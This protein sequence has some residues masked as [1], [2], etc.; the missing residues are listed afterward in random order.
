MLK[1]IKQGL[2]AG[3]GAVLLTKDKV[4]EAVQKLVKESKIN[5]AEA[6]KLTRELV[7]SGEK[8]WEDLEAS[9]GKSVR[10][11]VQSLDIASKKELQA[12]KRKVKKLEGRMTLIEEMLQDKKES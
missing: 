4:D 1:E 3:L 12:L 10:K 9:L 5:K 8:Q 2:F 7:D 11:G 6:E